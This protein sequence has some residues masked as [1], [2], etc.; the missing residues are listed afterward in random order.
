MDIFHKTWLTEGKLSENLW[1]TEV[2]IYDTTIL[3]VNWYPRTLATLEEE[4]VLAHWLFVKRCVRWKSCPLLLSEVELYI[5][6]KRKRGHQQSQRRT[7]KWAYPGCD[8]ASPDR[9]LGPARTWG[10]WSDCGTGRCTCWGQ[11]TGRP[12]RSDTESCC[13]HLEGSRAKCIS[14]QCLGICSAYFVDDD[15]CF[16]IALFSTL[17]QTHYVM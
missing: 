9:G 8:R 17:E 6:N 16:Y 11:R 3:Y 10:P 15:G 5:K 7:M 13:T 1:L 12:R 14:Q 2:A 4:D